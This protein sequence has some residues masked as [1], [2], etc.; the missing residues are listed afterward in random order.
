MR[1]SLAFWA[2]TPKRR[3]TSGS[4]PVL[5]KPL[6]IRRGSVWKTWNSVLVACSVMF[7]L[8][9][10]QRAPRWEERATRPVSFLPH[11]VPLRHVPGSADGG[12][13]LAL[14]VD[15]ALAEDRALHVEV[16]RQIWQILPMQAGE[17]P[18]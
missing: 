7:I 18:P 9:S 8:L 5:S 13:V 6:V 2:L 14:E 17:V 1:P 12:A 10:P 16:G 11:D 3:R 15:H 4:L